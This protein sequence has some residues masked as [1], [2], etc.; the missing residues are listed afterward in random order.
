MIT[1]LKQLWKD[2]WNPKN[3]KGSPHKM[4]WIGYDPTEKEYKWSV[5][6]FSYKTFEEAVDAAFIAGATEVHIGNM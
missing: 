4:L 1:K 5:K 2:H 3:S 6:G